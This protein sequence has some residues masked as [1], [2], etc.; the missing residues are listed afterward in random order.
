M[1]SVS[2]LSRQSTTGIR[3]VTSAGLPGH[4]SER[5]GRD[6]HTMPTQAGIERAQ[7]R[8][9]EPLADDNL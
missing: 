7:R 5:T 9:P 8:Q 6:V 3:V 4:I 2:A 1:A